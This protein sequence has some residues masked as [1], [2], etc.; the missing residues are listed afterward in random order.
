VVLPPKA[1]IRLGTHHECARY[2]SKSHRP[3][4]RSLG[5]CATCITRGANEPEKQ[6]GPSANAETS[7][8]HVAGQD[9]AKANIAHCSWIEIGERAKDVYG[10]AAAQPAESRAHDGAAVPVVLG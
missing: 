8:L 6:V 3:E 1:E 7:L 10:L 4:E 9:V 5:S 2:F